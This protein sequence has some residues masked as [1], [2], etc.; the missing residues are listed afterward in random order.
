MLRRQMVI[1]LDGELVVD[2]LNRIIEAEAGGVKA[3]A[4]IE[5]VWRRVR[6]KDFRDCRIHT[7]PARVV[8]RNIVLLNDTA[9]ITPLE[10]AGSGRHCD[11]RA[12]ADHFL[13][14]SLALIISKNEKLVVLDRA[15]ERGAE[16]VLNEFR[17]LTA[18]LVV[19]EV[20][21]VEVRIP[22]KVIGVAV[23]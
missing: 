17:N 1:P 6:R 9:R 11:N 4:H 10:D 15:A 14:R 23:V 8:L 5:I 18:R 12:V 2:T 19:E 3:V 21:R 20:V 13:L 7:N 22:Q 16:N